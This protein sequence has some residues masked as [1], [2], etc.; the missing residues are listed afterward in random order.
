MCFE[1][2]QPNR[3]NYEPIGVIQRGSSSEKRTRKPNV[4]KMLALIQEF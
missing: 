4:K 1:L 2:T 3:S